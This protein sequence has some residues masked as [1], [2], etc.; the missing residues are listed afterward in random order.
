MDDEVARSKA[1]TQR[2]KGFEEAR[3][4][5]V[6]ILVGLALGLLLGWVGFALSLVLAPL[7]PLLVGGPLILFKRTQAVGLGMIA[8]ACALI[9][10]VVTVFVLLAIF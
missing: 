2:L 3:R 7:P 8:A 1:K 5:P 6:L 10:V 4:Q 9:V